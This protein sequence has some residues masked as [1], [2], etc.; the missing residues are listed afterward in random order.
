MKNEMPDEIFA[1]TNV[2]ETE[3]GNWGLDPT[4]WV[5]EPTP[6]TRKDLTDRRT[7]VDALIE[8]LEDPTHDWNNVVEAIA[9]IRSGREGK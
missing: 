9:T 6:Y 2:A 8:V 7:D 1:V 5:I 3:I 4:V